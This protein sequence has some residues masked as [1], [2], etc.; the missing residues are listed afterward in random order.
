MQWRHVEDIPAMLR[1]PTA[2]EHR[3]RADRIAMSVEP[4]VCEVAFIDRAE[5]S[6]AP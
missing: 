3:E 1:D 4:H 6:A 5:A 2:T